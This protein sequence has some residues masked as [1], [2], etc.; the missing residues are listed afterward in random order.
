[1]GTNYS[2]IGNIIEEARN[3]VGCFSSCFFNHVGRD[4]NQVA[5]TLAKLGLT[6]DYDMIWVKDCPSYVEQFVIT[7]FSSY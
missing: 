3:R 5:E 1:M 2:I 7:D 6:V 4:G